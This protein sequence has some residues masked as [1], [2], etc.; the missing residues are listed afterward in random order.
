M[1]QIV[2]IRDIKPRPPEHGRIRLGEKG[3]PQGRV[4]LNRFRFTSA[5]REVIEQLAALYGGASRPWSDPKSSPQHQFEVTTDSSRIHIL[6]PV[7]DCYTIGYEQW[8]GRG[9][10]RRCDGEVC[11]FYGTGSAF[12][13][14]CMCAD[15]TEQTCKPYSRVNV[16]L[17]NV[18]LGG[19][20]RMEV[21]GRHFMYE[22]PGMIE[23]IL[24]L[25]EGGMAR[26]DLLLTQRTRRYVGKDGKPAVSKFIVPQFLV[27]MSPDQMLAGGARVNA[28]PPTVRPA[29]G[30]APDDDDEVVDAEVLD[31]SSWRQPVETDEDLS[32]LLEES[33][34]RIEDRRAG[35]QVAPDPEPEGWDDDNR[36]AGIRLR[37]NPDPNGPKWIRK[38]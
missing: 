27:P 23:T 20:W 37:R 9:I 31:L 6:L 5:D 22:A 14:P 25:H 13:R 11:I 24:S 28:L 35:L 21:K 34:R 1:A 30:P 15:Q 32:D 38:R 7:D 18:N 26:C 33:V 17:P 29:I 8:G 3:G 12:E 36:P 16:L 19:V 10:E 4:A 2:R